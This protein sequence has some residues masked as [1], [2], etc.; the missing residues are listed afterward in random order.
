MLN[1]STKSS[2]TLPVKIEA[3]KELLKNDL[4]TLLQ[5]QET[6]ICKLK[7]ILKSMREKSKDENINYG[8]VE[9]ETKNVKLENSV[10]K[11]ISEKERLCNEINHVKQELLVYVRDT[12]PNATNLS[13][14][15]VDVTPK[16]MS[17]KLGAVDPT[18]F[19]RKAGNDLLLY[20]KDT[21]ISLTADAD[22]TKCQD[23]RRSTSGSAQFIDCEFQFNKIPLYC[24]NKSKIALCCNNV[25]HSRPKHIDVRYYFIKEQVE[26][27]IMELYFVR[28]EYQLADIF[29][30]PLP[31]ERFNF[32]IEKLGMRSMSPETLK[33]LAEETDK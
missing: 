11:L 29:T 1:P 24:D 15:K 13:A 20:S 18:L 10:A 6:A 17:I 14:K 2:D 12:C 27:R 30:K 31:R 19:T 25:Q 16:T 28:T 26:N 4:K 3:L 22:H 21:G 23:T 32:L 33:H 7:D 8:Y 9:I 5:D